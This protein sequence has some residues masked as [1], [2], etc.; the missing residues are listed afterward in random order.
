L[1]GL[2]PLLQRLERAR[3]PDRDGRLLAQIER[4]EPLTDAKLELLLFAARSDGDDRELVREAIAMLDRHGID[5][6]LWP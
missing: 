3:R 4:L 6:E 2:R 5:V 1:A